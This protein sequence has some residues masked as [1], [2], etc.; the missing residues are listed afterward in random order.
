MSAKIVRTGSFW[1]ECLTADSRTKPEIECNTEYDYVEV[2]TYPFI[3]NDV[4]LPLTHAIIKKGDTGVIPGAYNNS[5]D[6][7]IYGF[8]LT[9]ASNGLSSSKYMSRAV[10]YMNA[11]FYKYQ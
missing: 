7:Q 1:M 10:L 2:T 4:M 11:T 8:D 9:A 6:M 3:R 5:G